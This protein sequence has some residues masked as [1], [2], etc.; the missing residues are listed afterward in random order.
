MAA[1]RPELS[2]DA[3]RVLRHAVKNGIAPA[4]QCQRSYAA[5]EELRKAGLAEKHPEFWAAYYYRITALGRA[6]LREHGQERSGT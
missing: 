3:S 6:Y 2:E 5:L 1:D 4:A